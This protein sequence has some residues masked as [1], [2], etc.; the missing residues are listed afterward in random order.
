MKEIQF[1]KLILKLEKSQWM[2]NVL[3]GVKDC[4]VR[5]RSYCVSR[6]VLGQVFCFVL[7]CS[8]CQCENFLRAKLFVRILSTAK[9]GKLASSEWREIYVS[10]ILQSIHSKSDSSTKRSKH[11]K[12]F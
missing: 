8:V 10:S 2:Q 6:E 12:M 7:F 9:S 3:V 4:G 5:G 1:I 11:E